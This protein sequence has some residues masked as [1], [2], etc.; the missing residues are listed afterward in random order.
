MEMS[1]RSH[2][3][4]LCLRENT[5]LIDILVTEHGV[6]VKLECVQVQRV[7]HN[8]RISESHDEACGALNMLESSLNLK[9]MSGLDPLKD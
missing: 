7:E 6:P 2:L 3:P 9:E 1:S 8:N 4:K 5:I